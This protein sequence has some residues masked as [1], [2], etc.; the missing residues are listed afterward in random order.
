V[1]LLFDIDGTLVLRA[2]R[3]HAQAMRDALR[4]VHGIREPRAAG[5]SAAGRTD[6]EIARLILLQCGVSAE[7]IDAGADEVRIRTCERYAALVP[8]DLT[9]EVPAGMDDLLDDLSA[10][11][12][13]RLSLVTG[14][15]EAVARLKLG[16][17]GL[18]H[19]FPAG[20]GGFG[21]DDEDRTE[22]PAIARARAGAPGEPWP[23]KRTVVIGDTPR[24]IACARVDGVRAVAIATGPHPPEELAGADAVVGSTPELRA[25]LERVL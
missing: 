19:H 7:R 20:Q 10:R 18:G 23:R 9:A 2:S 4:E 11:D 24:D 14:N 25:E 16:A 3:E 6:G 5:V 8:D 13:V 12:G 21:S 15:Y 1:L 17:A 22:L